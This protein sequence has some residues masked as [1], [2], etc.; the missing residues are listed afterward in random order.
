MQDEDTLNMAEVDMIVPDVMEQAFPDS[1]DYLNFEQCKEEFDPDNSG[2]IRKDQLV[3]FFKRMFELEEEDNLFYN[4][5]PNESTRP[6]ST[7]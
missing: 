7:D 2:C 4:G 1:M 6:R 5:N 3:P